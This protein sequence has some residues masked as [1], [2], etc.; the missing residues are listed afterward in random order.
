MSTDSDSL[1]EL[2]RSSRLVKNANQ[3]ARS[4][5][6]IRLHEELKEALQ[7]AGRLPIEDKRKPT[8]AEILK[9][10]IKYISDLVSGT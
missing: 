6:H 4:S 10:S 1:S 5:E 2:G 8:K 9:E 3:R 7:K